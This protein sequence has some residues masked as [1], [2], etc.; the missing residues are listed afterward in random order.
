MR[1][2]SKH[3]NNG[4]AGTAI[5]TYLYNYD[6][7]I[8]AQQDISSGISLDTTKASQFLSA[9]P[10]STYFVVWSGQEYSQRDAYR[11]RFDPTT[12][13]W[14][15]NGRYYSNGLAVCLDQ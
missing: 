6:G 14:Y 4:T 2:S 15:G 7:T 3:A 8:G 13:Y 10:Y 9:S 5:A 1:W 12:T 11:R